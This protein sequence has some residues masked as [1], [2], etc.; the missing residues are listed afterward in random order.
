MKSNFKI[1]IEV[2]ILILLLKL[3]KY[4]SFLSFFE[5]KLDIK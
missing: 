1:E 2:I 3:R 4:I 5:M